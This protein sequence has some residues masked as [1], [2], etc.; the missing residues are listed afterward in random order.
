M[1][2]FKRRLAQYEIRDYFFILCGTLLYGFAFNGFILSNEIVTGGLSGLCAL[3][4][5]A[6]GETIPVSVSYFVINIFLLGGALKVLG[7]RF[8]IKTIFGV[9]PLS[10]ALS[11]VE[12]ILDGRLIEGDHLLSFVHGGE[13]WGGVR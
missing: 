7:L 3:I 10:G 13:S 1:N 6:T 12:Q 5:F 11:L 9:F 8:L 2:E 4:F